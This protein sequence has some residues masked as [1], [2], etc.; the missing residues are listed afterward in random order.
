MATSRGSN[1]QLEMK[2]HKIQQHKRRNQYRQKQKYKANEAATD[3][4]QQLLSHK[5]TKSKQITDLQQLLKSQR[6]ILQKGNSL[7]KDIYKL[8]ANLSHPSLHEL[9][10]N[11]I[12]QFY[13]FFHYFHLWYKKKR[14]LC[15]RKIHF[16]YTQISVSP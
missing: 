2:I 8:P 3:R 9:P 4:Q 12:I 6:S 5:M 14:I 16:Q 13:L 1:K 10:H 15:I 7:S 11:F